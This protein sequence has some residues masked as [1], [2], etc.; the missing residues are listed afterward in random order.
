MGHNYSK[1]FFILEKK[2]LIEIIITLQTA[3]QEYNFK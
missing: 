3:Y 2:E 1:N